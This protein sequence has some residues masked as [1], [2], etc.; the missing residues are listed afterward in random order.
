MANP[1]PGDRDVVARLNRGIDTL[2]A[3][4]HAAEA[5]LELLCGQLDA[6]LLRAGEGTQEELMAIGL[7]TLCRERRLA[8]QSAA[9]AV[10][11]EI[12]ELPKSRRTAQNRLQPYFS[13]D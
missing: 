6:Q 2:F 8:M 10:S 13:E 9:C 12:A 1:M 11:E 4:I 7:K 3:Q 5:F